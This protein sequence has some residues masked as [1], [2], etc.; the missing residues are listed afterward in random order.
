MSDPAVASEF[1]SARQRIVGLEISRSQQPVSLPPAVT[2]ERIELLGPVEIPVRFHVIH[3]GSTQVEQDA[4]E[5]QVQVLNAAF[6]AGGIRFRLEGVSRTENAD[7]AQMDPGGASEREAKAVLGVEPESNLNVYVVDPPSGLLGWSVFPS[8]LAAEPENDGVVLSHATLPGGEPPFDRGVT[9]VHNVGHWLGLL[10]TF[11]DGCKEPGDRIGDTV[12]HAGPNFGRPA[13]GQAH[14]ACK[15]DE[16]AP[17]HNYMNY[18][19]DAWAD[20]FT[21]GQFRRMKESILAYRPK[22]IGQGDGPP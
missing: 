1:A 4:I 8:D 3:G 19:D 16:Q 5:A 10:H 11:Q 7:W 17:I 20:H 22:L 9:L 18:V 2:E 21:P 12:A 6:E 15:P 14:N 13:E